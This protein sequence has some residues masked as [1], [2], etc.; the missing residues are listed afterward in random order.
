MRKMPIGVAAFK[1]FDY[2][3]EEAISKST[4]VMFLQKLK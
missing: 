2:T 4:E 1:T 3:L